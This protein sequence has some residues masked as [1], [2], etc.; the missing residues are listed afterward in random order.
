[1]KTLPP[2]PKPRLGPEHERLSVFVGSWTSE[3]VTG[4]LGSGRM[5]M[6][7]RHTYELLPGGFFLIH[8]WEGR[9]GQMDNQGIEIIAPDRSQFFDG[10]GWARTYD[11]SVD[12]NAWRFVGERERAEMVF[13]NDGDT[14]Y[15]TWEQTKDGSSW[16]VLCEVKATKM[17]A[18]R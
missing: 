12:G 9:I 18:R 8:R 3:G 6:A 13:T 15:V 4:D 14:M 16:T 11:V 1:M 5:Q 10:S 7:Q 17:R 2:E